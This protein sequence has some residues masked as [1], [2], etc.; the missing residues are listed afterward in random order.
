MS[1]IRSIVAIASATACVIAAPAVHAQGPGNPPKRVAPTLDKVL[2]VLN[3]AVVRVRTPSESQLAGSD[4]S[5]EA[6]RDGVAT[7]ELTGLRVAEDLALVTVPGSGALP[8]SFDAG[9]FGAWM[10]ARVAASDAAQR[11][12]LLKLAGTREPAPAL[13]AAA[14][15]NAGF[16]V[17]AV[18]AGATLDIKT[19]WVSADAPLAAPAGAVVFDPEG[20][21][22]GVVPAAGGSLTPGQAVL[23]RGS[24]LAAKAVLR[25]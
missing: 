15:P 8:A 17:T 7:T 1:A 24:A 5:I 3:R 12:V 4:A 2:P 14:L 11:A 22:L 19:V 13:A 20:R 25:P 6:A 18:S 21:L 23:D 10:P 16:V 9:L